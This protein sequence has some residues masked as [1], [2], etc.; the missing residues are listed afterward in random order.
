VC[1]TS[2][3]TFVPFRERSQARCP[4]CESLERH[5]LIWLYLHGRTDLFDGRAKSLLHIAPEP[6]ISARLAAVPHVRYVTA[7]LF[8]DAMVQVDVARAPFA[9]G[10]FD[11]IYASHVLEHVEDDAGAMREFHRML[12]PGGWA[13]LQVPVFPLPVT[14]EDPRVRTPEDRQRVYGQSDHVRMYGRDYTERLEGAGFRVTV[15][16][17]ALSIPTADAERMGIAPEDIYL[18]RK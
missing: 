9:D 7:D 17:F 3:R 8:A 5:R 4:I 10:S 11:V 12:R 1:E 6:A 14:F 18:C 13:V 16:D 15:D 2:L